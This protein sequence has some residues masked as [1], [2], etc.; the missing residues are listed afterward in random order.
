MHFFS[1]FQLAWAPEVANNSN[2]NNKS[3]NVLVRAVLGDLRSCSWAQGL[4]DEQFS[5]IAMSSGPWQMPYPVPG[6]PLQQEGTEETAD[7]AL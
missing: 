6:S 5:W 1:I 4:A 7:W 2:E 3:I